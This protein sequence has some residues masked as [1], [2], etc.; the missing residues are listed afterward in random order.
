MIL[1]T[2]ELAKRLLKFKDGTPV[3]IKLNDCDKE[4]IVNIT[5]VESTGSECLIHGHIAMAAYTGVDD[6]SKL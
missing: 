3:S 6:W 1:K 2:N 5:A 4:Y